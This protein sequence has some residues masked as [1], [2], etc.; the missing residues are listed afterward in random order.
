MESSSFM[1]SYMLEQF[2]Q[3]PAV[4]GCWQPHSNNGKTFVHKFNEPDATF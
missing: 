3:W 1:G 2:V 4:A